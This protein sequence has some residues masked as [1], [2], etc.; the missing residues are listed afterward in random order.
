MSSHSALSWLDGQE[1]HSKKHLMKTIPTVVDLFE[2]LI[3]LIAEYAQLTT[4]EVLHDL[5]DNS[6]Y[7]G[8]AP[9]VA[10]LL[11][12]ECIERLFASR[13]LLLS[14]YQGRMLASLR[15]MWEAIYY[16]DICWQSNELASNWLSGDYLP[17][18]GKLPKG[19]KINAIISKYRMGE[20]WKFL[21]NGLHPTKVSRQR[22]VGQR[23]TTTVAIIG[24]FVSWSR[25]KL[26]DFTEEV[27]YTNVWV[28]IL[29]AH[30]LL[31]YLLDR[32]DTVYKNHVE[33]Q[34]EYK[35]LN[36]RLNINGRILQKYEASR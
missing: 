1:E 16:S 11:L 27:S 31:S 32:Y 7:R 33:I 6:E 23:G 26:S 2:N 10:L 14:G 15:D 35:R 28:A 30:N 3:N 5:K 12:H 13:R 34:H 17:K 4:D 24:D 25:E 29:S 18:P 20:N 22:S 9:V 8:V 36:R 21:S 19:I